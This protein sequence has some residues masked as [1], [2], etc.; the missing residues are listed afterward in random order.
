MMDCRAWADGSDSVPQAAMPGNYN[1]ANEKTK[2]VE[3][4]A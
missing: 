4:D 3:E 2:G 1:L